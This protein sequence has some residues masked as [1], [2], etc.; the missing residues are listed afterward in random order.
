MS[1]SDKLVIAT[2]TS[3]A[4][5][6]PQKFSGA[7]CMVSLAC[8]SRSGG[9]QHSDSAKPKPK[10]QRRNDTPFCVSDFKIWSQDICY[11]CLHGS[12]R[13]VCITVNMETI[14]YRVE[15]TFAL[16]PD[17]LSVSES[18]PVDLITPPS[19]LSTK[20]VPPPEQIHIQPI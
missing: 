20:R 8:S 18:S 11:R 6:S 7:A 3:P 14:I 12:N 13:R 16:I 19:N 1:C 9:K 10:Q 17:L 15:I 4:T 5:P 2:D